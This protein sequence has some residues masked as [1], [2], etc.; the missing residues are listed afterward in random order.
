MRAFTKAKSSR[1]TGVRVCPSIQQRLRNVPSF[2]LPVFGVLSVVTSMPSSP[3]AGCA[4][5]LLEQMVRRARSPMMLPRPNWRS[6]LVSMTFD[7]V[8][9]GPSALEDSR[10]MHS[11][12]CAALTWQGCSPGVLRRL[13]G[14]IFCPYSP[15]ARKETNIT[16]KA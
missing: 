12:G 13:V 16:S 3:G 7:W 6:P 2:A 1:N 14:Q 11:G 8:S 4:W 5:K 10:F 9:R 15:P